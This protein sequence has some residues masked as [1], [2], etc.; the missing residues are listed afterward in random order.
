MRQVMKALFVMYI[1]NVCEESARLTCQAA[2][3]SINMTFA[4][5]AVQSRRASINT[6]QSSRPLDA[7]YYEIWYDK[8]TSRL[9]YALQ[10]ITPSS[11]LS[12]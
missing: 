4:R 11:A 2:A 1:V 12:F 5:V 7:R 8:D 10:R 6:P 9:I 3:L